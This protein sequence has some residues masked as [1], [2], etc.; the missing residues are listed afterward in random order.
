MESVWNARHDSGIGVIDEQHHELFRM[1]ERLRK[2]IQAGAAGSSVEELL[3]ELVTRT[4]CHFAT[5]EAFM[6]KFGYPDLKQ[7][8]SEHQSM[9]T[10][11][12]ELKATF[13]DSRQAMVMMVPTFLEGWL[14][15]HISDG[16]FGFITFLKAHNLV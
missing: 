8:V 3:E 11:L 16:D 9:L 1:V 2:L 13:Q 7:H 15:H 12:Q 10:S 4:E 14:R 5:E 6:S